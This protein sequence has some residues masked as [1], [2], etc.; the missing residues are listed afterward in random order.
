MQ[1]AR[2]CAGDVTKGNKLNVICG[3]D[4]WCV[5]LEASKIYELL[6]E[7]FF[8]INYELY[9]ANLIDFSYISMK[10]LLKTR[11]TKSGF[12]IEP[13]NFSIC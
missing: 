10:K 13:E 5:G 9:S 7:K 8:F 4:K 2:C 1:V 11:A 12:M 6:S 3:M